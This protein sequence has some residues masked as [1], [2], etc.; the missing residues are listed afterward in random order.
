MSKFRECVIN[1]VAVAASYHPRD[2][3]L[4]MFTEVRCGVFQPIYE[5][6]MFKFT[7]SSETVNVQEKFGFLSANDFAFIKIVLQFADETK[8]PAEEFYYLF[9][10]LVRDPTKVV[11][12]LTDGTRVRIHLDPEGAEFRMRCHRKQA[13]PEPEEV[14]PNLLENLVL[15]QEFVVKVSL[16]RRITNDFLKTVTEK[17]IFRDCWMLFW[18]GMV[19]FFPKLMF[20]GLFVAHF[21]TDLNFRFRCLLLSK[22]D[23]YFAEETTAHDLKK[24][25]AWIRSQQRALIDFTDTARESLTGEAKNR[26]LRLLFNWIV[27]LCP[28]FLF[29]S[30]LSFRVIVF[31]V[32][33]GLVLVKYQKEAKQH[34]QKYL[35]PIPRIQELLTRLGRGRL[36]PVHKWSLRRPTWATKK[37][38]LVKYK[39]VFEEQQM[40]IRSPVTKKTLI[41]DFRDMIE[42]RSSQLMTLVWEGSKPRQLQTGGD[43]DPGWEWTGEWILVKS[44]ITDS[45]GWVYNS[46]LPSFLQIDD[47][48]LQKT[49][50]RQWIR[51]CACRMGASQSCLFL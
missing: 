18:V 40:A 35:K 43:L 49:R 19:L 15:T 6:R 45:E 51:A 16:T 36:P 5:S 22:F 29:I 10:D 20:L 26:N 3:R 13:T 31:G 8:H 42:D 11:M 37:S 41:Q 44:S 38:K 9:S 4:M 34:L 32:A 14:T 7:G 28:A 33:G 47:S 17:D 24:N 25:L 1:K 50:K 2:F 39:F 48:R 30:F 27:C 21:F 23:H 46:S 12:H